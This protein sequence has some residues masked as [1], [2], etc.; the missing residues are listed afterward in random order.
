MPS[1]YTHTDCVTSRDT[2]FAQYPSSVLSAKIITHG[3][4]NALTRTGNSPPKMSLSGILRTSL[5]TPYVPIAAT[6]VHR[7][8]SP[9]SQPP[10]PENTFASRH[11]TYSAGMLSM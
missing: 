8:P 10:Y 2:K 3:T 1:P 7:L 11:P 4:P 9:M 5:P 6:S